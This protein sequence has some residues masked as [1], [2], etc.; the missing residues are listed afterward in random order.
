[1]ARHRDFLMKK[2][3]PEVGDPQDMTVATNGAGRGMSMVLA[4]QWTT[5]MF[6]RSF[7]PSDEARVAGHDDSDVA[8]NEFR[9]SNKP[10]AAPT[11]IVSSALKTKAG[12]C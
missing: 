12:G 4:M 7:R 6:R 5:S 3:A 1:M 9:G 10:V 8:I 2:K 11:N